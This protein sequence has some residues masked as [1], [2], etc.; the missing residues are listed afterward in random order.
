VTEPTDQ[1]IQP[2][3]RAWVEVRARP[4]TRADRLRGTRPSRWGLDQVDRPRA[5]PTS[6]DTSIFQCRSVIALYRQP[7]CCNELIHFSTVLSYFIIL[8]STL[9]QWTLPFFYNIQLFYWTQSLCYSELSHLLSLYYITQPFYYSAQAF[10]DFVSHSR[11][12]IRHFSTCI[13]ILWFF[14]YSR[15]SVRH[16]A[17][18]H[19]HFKFHQL[20]FKMTSAGAYARGRK[21]VSIRDARL[22]RLGV[23]IRAHKIVPCGGARDWAR[24]IEPWGCAG[25]SRAGRAG[26]QGMGRIRIWLGRSVALLGPGDPSH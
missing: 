7:F 4:F 14:S 20:F 19:S 13:V 11:Y 2:R 22:G 12:S 25:P 16:F 3:A 26:A 10:Y 17:I 18:V 9:V 23:G 21:Y 1:A 5:H 24:G 15:D 8:L 6:R